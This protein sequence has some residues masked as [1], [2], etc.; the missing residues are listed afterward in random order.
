MY[1][2]KNNV[3]FACD[4]YKQEKG[5]M[6]VIMAWE[7]IKHTKEFYKRYGIDYGNPVYNILRTDRKLY[8]LGITSKPDVKFPYVRLDF[9]GSTTQHGCVHG[10][11][12]NAYVLGYHFPLHHRP[13]DQWVEYWKEKIA[14]AENYIDQYVHRRR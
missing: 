9:Y 11:L 7:G 10:V 13:S 3:R 12:T 5:R 14:V 2:V 8:E 1:N 4:G 6:Y